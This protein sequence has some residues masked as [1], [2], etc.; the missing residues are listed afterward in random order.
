MT[1][2]VHP[3]ALRTYAAQL[4]EARQAAEE[5]KRY[6][7]HHGSFSLHDSGLFGKAAPG[8]RHVMAALDLL[9]DRLA[10]LTDT[11]SLALLQVAAGYERTDDQAAARI[12]ASY[13]AV[14]R[15]APNR[16]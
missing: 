13:P 16:D 10:R 3:E 5:A 1:F 4:D 7:T 2:T 12:D 15:P 9:L 11:S 8:H 6:I 14:P